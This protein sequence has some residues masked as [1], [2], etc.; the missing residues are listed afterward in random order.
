[1]KTTIIYLAITLITLSNSNAKS[2]KRE[3]SANQIE[4]NENDL[5]ANISNSSKQE[6]RVEEMVVFN[7]ETVINVTKEKPIEEI[8]AE[9]N[10]I[11]EQPISNEIYFY[12]N[13]KPVEQIIIEN[14]QI[15]EEANITDVKPLYLD[16]SIDEIINEDNAIIESTIINEVYPL[17]FDKINQ[18][19]AMGKQITL[20]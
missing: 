15:I 1:M 7:P 16:L 4:Q 14:N 13:E 2:L 19:N 9:N 12:N 6:T 5:A 8:I 10:Q 17:D 3:I 18:K 20:N 11:I